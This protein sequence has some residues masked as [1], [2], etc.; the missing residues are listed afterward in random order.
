MTQSIINNVDLT[1]SNGYYWNV[2][3]LPLSIKVNNS[4]S[5]NN[6]HRLL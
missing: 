6:S 2:G 4:G 5:G 1:K 3:E